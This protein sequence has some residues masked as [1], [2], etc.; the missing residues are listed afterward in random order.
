MSGLSVEQ[1]KRQF[2]A[3]TKKRLAEVLQ[4]ERI[5]YYLDAAGWPR[6]TWEAIN[7]ALIGQTKQRTTEDQGFN[8][9]GVD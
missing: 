7:H 8:L 3:S 1:M 9:E 2:S 5:Q 4:R 6:T